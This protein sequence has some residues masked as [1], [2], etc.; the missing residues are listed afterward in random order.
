MP[1]GMPPTQPMGAMGLSLGGLSQIGPVQP[2]SF[3]P[4]GY[5]APPSDPFQRPD[6]Q[7]S[8]GPPPF[9]RS[10]YGDDEIGG[11]PSGF[12]DRG[13]GGFDRGGRGGFSDRGRGGGRGR[14]FGGDRGGRGGR[15]GGFGGDRGG[16][17]GR[18]G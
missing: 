12:S 15:D 18:D 7:N 14:G 17:G 11:P 4:K 10:A 6:S 1:G 5:G 3:A 8:G 13:P 16:R 2:P 9:Y